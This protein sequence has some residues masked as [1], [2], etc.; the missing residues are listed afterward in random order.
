M[1]T[2]WTMVAGVGLALAVGPSCDTQSRPSRA[3]ATTSDNRAVGLA[4]SSLEGIPRLVFFAQ[5][6]ALDPA[7]T[8][9]DADQFVTR[10]ID[11]TRNALIDEF[12][13]FGCAVIDIQADGNT[14][15]ALVSSCPILTLTFDAEVDVV[16]QLV[17]ADPSECSEGFCPVAVLWDFD[18]SQLTIGPAIG[19]RNSFSG[20][21]QLRAPVDPDEPMGW[22]TH[23]GY[24]LET[25]LGPRFDMLSTATWTSDA[26]G[27]MDMDIGSRLQVEETD[28]PLDETLGDIV[29]SSRGVRRCPFQCTLAGDVEVS[30]QS[31]S[32][33]R[34]SFT[35]EETLLVTGPLGKTL[36]VDLPCNGADEG[37][38][39]E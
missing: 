2:P 11:D 1:K 39:N 13:R 18:I 12:S 36:E 34:W 24:T 38:A 3:E 9:D 5:H 16:A 14:L 35:G 23:P 4:A 28:E 25:R 10:A 8:A 22:Q 20:P 26:E 37:S 7:L 15:S 32:L 19:R 31:G 27:C 30:F 17:E 29:I 33:L 6:F 21:A